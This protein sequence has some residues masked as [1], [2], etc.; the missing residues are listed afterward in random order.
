MKKD[1]QKKLDAVIAELKKLDED[2]K[3]SQAQIN[4]ANKVQTARRERFVLLSGKKQSFEELLEE[5]KPE[6]KDEKK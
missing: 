3:S 1:I 6:V 4:E 2:F 5:D